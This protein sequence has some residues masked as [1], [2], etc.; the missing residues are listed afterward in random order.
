MHI[1]TAQQMETV[2][3]MGEH[4]KNTMP[5]KLDNPPLF[6]QEEFDISMVEGSLGRLVCKVI[7]NPHQEEENFDLFMGEIVAAWS[8]DRV[9][10]NG[11]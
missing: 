5:D 3:Y 9:F 8:G 7:P 4:R 2:L 10:K 1:P 6:Y 11:Y